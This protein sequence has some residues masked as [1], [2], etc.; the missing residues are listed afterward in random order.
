MKKRILIAIIVFIALVTLAACVLRG[1]KS[2]SRENDP[3][4][5]LSKELYEVESALKEIDGAWEMES[6]SKVTPY[7]YENPEGNAFT[8]YCCTTGYFSKE[9]TEY[10]GIHK[11]VI[12]QIVDIDMLENRRACAVNG[13]DAVFGELDGKT[14]LCWTI[15]PQ[16]S[17][18]VEYVTG[19]MDEEVILKMAESVAEKKIP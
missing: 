9:A 14:Y 18:I 4:W 1:T 2:D 7:H 10:S 11:A 17:C 8:Y 13:L 5:Q 3:Y 16:Y 15:S 12:E 19:T 6:L